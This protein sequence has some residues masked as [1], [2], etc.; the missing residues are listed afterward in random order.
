MP[1]AW[2]HSRDILQ[3]EVAI[4]LARRFNVALGIERAGED[5]HPHPALTETATLSEEGAMAVRHYPDFSTPC[6]GKLQPRGAM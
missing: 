1:C 4:P 2:Y 3:P 6:N 5:A